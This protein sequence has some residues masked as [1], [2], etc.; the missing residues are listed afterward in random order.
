VDGGGQRWGT[1]PRHDASW[2]PS[3]LGGSSIRMDPLL[4][5]AKRR[6]FSEPVFEQNSKMKY[7]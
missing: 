3:V 5:R 2:P 7:T 6:A 1:E 4:R